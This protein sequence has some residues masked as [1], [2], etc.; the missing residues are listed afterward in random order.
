M[1]T[2]ADMTSGDDTRATEP[3]HED[4][5][6]PDGPA[7]SPS[8]TAPEVRL[9][10][11]LAPLVGDATLSSDQADAVYRGFMATDGTNV[12]GRRATDGAGASRIGAA[13]AV[14]GIGLLGAGFL[15]GVEHI[16]DLSPFGDRGTFT[17]AGAACAL[18]LA[19][20]LA[21]GVLAAS[22]ST[23]GR[24]WRPRGPMAVVASTALSVVLLGV[25][26]VLTVE[27]S[28][29]GWVLATGAVALVGGLA[30]YLVLRGAPLLVP[31]IGGGVL[32]V[33]QATSH[34]D[35]HAGS[36]GH[37]LMSGMVMAGYGV[38]VA[39][40]GWRTPHRHLIGVLGGLVALASL[41][42]VILQNGFTGAFSLTDQGIQISYRSDTYTAL[43]VG[44][45]VCLGMVVASAATGHAGFAVTGFI[46]AVVLPASAGQFITQKHP[47]EVG[48][49]FGGVGVLLVLVGLAVAWRRRDS[50][51]A[52]VA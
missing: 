10:D 4:E 36:H 24:G 21:I 51:T 25:A 39:L 22:I 11:V 44:L 40:A 48:A 18:A 16:G 19:G 1:T 42:E 6:R 37:L 46:G 8:T 50:G 14:L 35:A 17:R 47:L 20:V 43:I 38:L 7:A 23:S 2:P 33:T 26:L 13:L 9:A 32:L 12:T 28:S 34:I 52:D 27:G 41:E 29:D 5:V 3:P 49:T 31:A 30:G 15:M 45:V